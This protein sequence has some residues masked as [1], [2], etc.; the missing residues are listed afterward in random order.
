MHGIELGTYLGHRL[1]SNLDD[2][3]AYLIIVPNGDVEG[4]T[5]RPY[6][7]SIRL[8]ICRVLEDVI[9]LEQP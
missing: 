5:A 2:L 3:L 4:E 8:L 9:H 6:F 1:S 7:T